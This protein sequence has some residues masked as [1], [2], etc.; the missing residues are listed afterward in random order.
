MAGYADEAWR[1]TGA[2]IRFGGK[3]KTKAEAFCLA[4]IDALNYWRDTLRQR[5]MTIERP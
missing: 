4:A 3:G 1:R 2:L 5:Q